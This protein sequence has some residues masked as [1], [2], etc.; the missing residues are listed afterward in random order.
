MD[1]RLHW[2]PKLREVGEIL[3]TLYKIF[4]GPPR[5][6]CPKKIC[7]EKVNNHNDKNSIIPAPP[8][9]LLVILGIMFSYK[10]LLNEQELSFDP[11]GIVQWKDKLMFLT[12]LFHSN[13]E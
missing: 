13:P 3:G 7:K 2:Y 10:D 9:T 4:L 6:F 11:R 1:C 8:S 12:S 5:R